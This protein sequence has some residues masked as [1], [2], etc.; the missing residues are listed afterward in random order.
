MATDFLPDP[1]L[2]GTSSFGPFTITIEPLAVGLL[3]D[4]I[5]G[6]RALMERLKAFREAA[7]AAEPDDTEI[8]WGESPFFDVLDTAATQPN[9]TI[10]FPENEQPPTTRPPIQYD[11]VY[12]EEED[13]RIENPEDEEQYVDTKRVTTIIFL[14]QET[15]LLH[16]FNLNYPAEE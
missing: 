14:C 16:Q 6:R 10:R 8:R 2:G 13:L 4:D 11:E 3:P 1:D 15:G 9:I 12:R 7:A 5:Y